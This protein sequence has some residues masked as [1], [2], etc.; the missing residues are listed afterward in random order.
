MGTKNDITMTN[1]FGEKSINAVESI[2]E[3]FADVLPA[4]SE[5]AALEAIATADA[6]DLG[7]AVALANACKAKINAIIVALKA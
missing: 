7:T 2:A 5:V 6:T 4:K 3:D 1:Q